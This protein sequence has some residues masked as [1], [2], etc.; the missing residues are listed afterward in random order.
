[1]FDFAMTLSHQRVH[2]FFGWTFVHCTALPI[3]IFCDGSV[4]V[5][6]DDVEDDDCIVVF[7]WGNSG[8]KNESKLN[9]NMKD[10]DENRKDTGERDELCNNIVDTLSMM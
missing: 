7:A 4:H 10:S 8:G 3:L 5:S 1:M 9:A 6:N 2:N